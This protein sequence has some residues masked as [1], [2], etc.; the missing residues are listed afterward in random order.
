MKAKVLR[1]IRTGEAIDSGE[2]DLTRNVITGK[3]ETRAEVRKKA[4]QAAR[5]L[6]R[7]FSKDTASKRWSCEP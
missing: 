7:L 2:E 5:R 1:D 4:R 3:W 6:M